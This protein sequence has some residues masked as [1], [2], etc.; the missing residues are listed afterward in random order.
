MYILIFT[1][2]ILFLLVFIII[3]KAKNIPLPKIKDL[4][5]LELE[6]KT[7]ENF[8]KTSLAF[9]QKNEFGF[10]E[11]Y[12][13]G[14][15]FERGVAM[16]K[17][18]EKVKL[19]HE[20]SFISSIES[21]IPSPTYL[22]FLKIFVG[23]FNRNLHHF[24]NKEYLEELYGLSFSSS[25]KYNYIAPPFQRVLNYHAAHDIGHA[26]QNIGLVGCSSFVV[27]DNKSANNEL[28][29]ARNLDFSPSE[30][31]NELKALYFIHP[32]KGNK[33]V[34]YSWPGFIGVVSGMNEHG[35]C[36]V[37]HSAKSK[38]RFSIGTPV[39]IIAREIMQEAKNI[40]EA[41]AILQK[42]QAFVS[43]LFLV[44]SAQD[45]S[46][47][48]FE[49]EPNTLSEYQMEN[50]NLICVNHLLSKKNK[51][52]KE[53]LE[54]KVTISSAYREQRLKEL[55]ANYQSISPENAAEIL[56]DIKG[57]NNENIG[58]Q[59]ENAINQL[60]AHHGVIFKP[61]SLEFWVS[62][63][64]YMMG[65]MV[66][67]D[68]NDAFEKAIKKEPTILYNKDKTIDKDKFLNTEAY[69][70]FLKFEQEKKEILEAIKN[71]KQLSPEILL[72]FEKHNPLFFYTHE[73]L[74]D[75]YHKNK[76]VTKAKQHY[77][78]ALALNIPTKFEQKRIEKKWRKL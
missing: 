59:N 64:P 30:A 7:Q 51:N 8:V 39:S 21:I 35:L 58:L 60:A 45:N 18:M 63:N 3:Y 19:K 32:N 48:V 15:P 38:M 14:A 9:M 49:K 71:K 61:Q 77:K 65:E 52:S 23:I 54:W 69:A 16:G 10:Y 29:L 41:R 2:T 43:E 47:V 1:I 68:F 55:L 50:N 34:S 33:Y 44:V 37:L 31:F 40:D 67:Y 57:C 53:N 12:A 17:V 27:K 78:T 76:N 5:S 13:E 20:E 66:A 28:L 22:N 73:I 25:K 72:S 75:Y 74:G 70:D 6:V 56:R 26:L 36:V 46:A 11:I 42:R 24:F 4:S 62:A